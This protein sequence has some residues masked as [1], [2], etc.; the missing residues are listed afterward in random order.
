MEKKF[1]IT[2]KKFE[3]RSSKSEIA[4]NRFETEPHPLAPSPWH[5]EGEFIAELF[6]AGD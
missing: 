5:G 6:A 2:D 3:I 1:E 4:D